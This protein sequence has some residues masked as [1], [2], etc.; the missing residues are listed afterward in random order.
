MIVLVQSFELYKYILENNVYPREPSPLKEIRDVTTNHPTY[1]M[2]TAPDTAQLMGMLLKLLNAKKAIEIGVYT[3]YS[4]LLT[5]LSIPRD[6]MII[7]I[8]PDREAYEIGLPI[9][10]KAGVEHKINFIESK[11][12]PVLDKLLQN[13]K[14][15]E[16]SFDFAF[17]DA[18]KDNYL[19]YHGR[20]L[21][22]V[23]VDGLIV[24]DNTL[25]GG[26]VVQPEEDVPGKRKESWTSFIVFN[27]SIS[28]DQHEQNIRF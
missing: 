10:Q 21:K 26:T 13:Q 19:N 5:A 6:A 20:L 22:L 9:F 16:G 14:E 27:K 3:G 8:D 23:K 7:G 2:S 12:L 1:F 15:N 24:F 18:D 25:W 4:L 28:R 17:I 11:A